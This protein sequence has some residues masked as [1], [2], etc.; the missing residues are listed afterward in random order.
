MF[1]ICS[2]FVEYLELRLTTCVES[3]DHGRDAIFRIS[4]DERGETGPTL[5]AKRP[6]LFQRDKLLP[7][8]VK[9]IKNC[10]QGI[11]SLPEDDL[12]AAEMIKSQRPKDVKLIQS[13]PSLVIIVGS[14]LSGKYV[15]H[16]IKSDEDVCFMYDTTYKLLVNGKFVSVLLM[17]NVFLEPGKTARTM[18][19]AAPALA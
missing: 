13:W 15:E 8:N 1:K 3:A 19:V 18:V 5:D 17:P 9:Q 10:K 7:R 2:L 16:F 12:S 6:A 14:E 11:R 4:D